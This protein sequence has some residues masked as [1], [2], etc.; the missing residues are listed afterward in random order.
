MSMSK[1]IKN[2]E[3]KRDEKY[4]LE[5]SLKQLELDIKETNRK[6]EGLK[7]LLEELK[8]SKKITLEELSKLK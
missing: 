5:L 1:I 7:N 8:E 4:E 3:L 6:I 2:E